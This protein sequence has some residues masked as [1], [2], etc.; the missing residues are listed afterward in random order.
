MQ[1]IKIFFFNFAL[2]L[3]TCLLTITESSAKESSIYTADSL[4]QKKKYTEAFTEYSTIFEK[5]KKF[6]S[7]M[8]LKMAFI[9]E[10][11][12]DYSDA[13]YYLSVL[14][15]HFPNQELQTK[16]NNLAEAHNI[17]GYDNYEEQITISFLQKN[18]QVLLHIT[19]V[20]I[21]ISFLGFSLIKLLYKKNN[22]LFLGLC[23]ISSFVFFSFQS[24]ISNI[25]YGISSQSYSYLMTSPSSASDVVE[26]LEKKGHFLKIINKKDV[27][28]EVELNGVYQFI[29]ESN[30]RLIP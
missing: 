18:K 12:G 7:Q 3:F 14:Q 17:W 6:S 16:V 21:G 15:H 28:Y 9:Q 26:I 1:N 2:I 22:Y 13:L 8:L 19:L 24:F 25:Q 4:F 11:L 5:Q 27:W 10:G 20:C 29:H 23:I 30:I